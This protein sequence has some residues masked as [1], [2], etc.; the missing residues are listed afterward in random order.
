M[1]GFCHC[2]PSSQQVKFHFFLSGTIASQV[3]KYLGKNVPTSA[4]DVRDTGSTPASGGSPGE[5]IGNPLQYS[6]L[7]NPTHR[8]VLWATV[9]GVIKSQ[10]MTE[11]TY[12]APL[13]VSATACAAAALKVL[14][15]L[16]HSVWTHSIE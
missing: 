8:V 10:D 6:C 7:G 1:N 11:V 2:A 12:Q 15:A 4:G 13:L 14:S 3:V 5:G 16:K 9:H